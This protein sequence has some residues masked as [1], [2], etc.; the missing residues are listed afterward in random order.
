VAVAVYFFLVAFSAA[1]VTGSFIRQRKLRVQKKGLTLST[2]LR[3]ID[4]FDDP[5]GNGLPHITNGETTKR[6]VL[7]VALYT[8]RFAGHKLGNASIAG[9]DE[10]G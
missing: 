9:L 5:N 1:L 4:R 7:I 3:F 2:L 8:H 6:G 10:L